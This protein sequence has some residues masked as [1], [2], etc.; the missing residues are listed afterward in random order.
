MGMVAGV[1]GYFRLNCVP[2]SSV[3]GRFFRSNSLVPGE[4]RAGLCTDDTDHHYIIENS[5]TLV[6]FASIQLLLQS[7][8]ASRVRR[9]ANLDK[10][11]GG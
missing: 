10:T 9:G 1:P 7:R 8:D 11:V 2:R 3:M 5:K 6:G 4:P